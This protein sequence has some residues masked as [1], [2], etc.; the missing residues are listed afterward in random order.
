[1][2]LCP[3]ESNLTTKFRM[4]GAMAVFKMHFRLKAIALG[5]LNTAT[6]YGRTKN[7]EQT[8]CKSER[9]VGKT[10]MLMPATLMGQQSIRPD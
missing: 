8:F 4:D 1:M 6:R 7:T 9:L 2:V 5:K 10:L 3:N